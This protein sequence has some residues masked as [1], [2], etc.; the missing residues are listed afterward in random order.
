MRNSFPLFAAREMVRAIKMKCL[1]AVAGVR[2]FG[3]AIAV[4]PLWQFAF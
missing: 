1:S 3:I 4:P 2:G